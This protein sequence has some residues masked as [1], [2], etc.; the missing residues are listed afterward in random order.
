MPKAKN[1]HVVFRLETKDWAAKKEGNQKA[2]KVFDT[3]KEAEQAGRE[4]AKSE[5]SELIIHNKDGKISG[6]DS[7]GNDPEGV[8]G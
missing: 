5:K 1:V 7:G 8:P 2:S 6:K 4:L 3:K